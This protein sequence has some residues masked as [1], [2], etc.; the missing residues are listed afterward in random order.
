ML[1]HSVPIRT[2]PFST[3]QRFYEALRIKR[4]RPTPR[5][6][7]LAIQEMKTL[8]IS[9]VQSKTSVHAPQLS[10]MYWKKKLLP[11]K[12]L[13]RFFYL[14]ISLFRYSFILIKA[15]GLVLHASFQKPRDKA[16]HTDLILLYYILKYNIHEY[17]KYNMKFAI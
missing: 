11:S 8:N 1:K 6:A 17:N 3:F 12:S 14:R 4:R 5:F 16:T 9:T 13:F 10:L 15:K 2:L 7:S